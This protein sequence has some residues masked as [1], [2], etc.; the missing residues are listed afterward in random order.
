MKYQE[1]IFEEIKTIARKYFADAEIML[2]G[3]RARKDFHPASDYDIL[4]MIRKSIPVKDKLTLKTMIRKDL[5]ESNIRTDI[6]I[7]S[8]QEIEEKKLLPGHI[9]RTILKEAILL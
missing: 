9:I 7:Q 4:I 2:F 5:L 1:K 3:S 6:L 8:K